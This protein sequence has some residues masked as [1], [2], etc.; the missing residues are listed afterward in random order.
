MAGIHYI[1]NIFLAITLVFWPIWFSKR[2]LRLPYINPLSIH[3]AVNVPVE[4]MKLVVGPMFLIED[5]LFD[6]GYQYAIA[7]SNLNTICEVIG[8]IFS[9]RLFGYLHVEKL[10]P[11]LMTRLSSAGLRNASTLFLSLFIAFFFLLSSNEFGF[12]NWI[13]NPR[14]GYQLHRSGQGLWFALAI[15][16][17]AVSFYIRCLS[18]KNASGVVRAAIAY[19]IISYF[20]GSKGVMLWYFESTLIMLWFVGYRKL[21]ILA[22]VGLP[23]IFMAMTFNLYLALG[24][25]FEPNSVVSYFDYYVNGASYYRSFHDGDIGLF[26][27]DIFITSFWDY[28]PR[29]VWPE[30]PVVYGVTIINEVFFPGHAELT[31]TP[32]FGGAVTQFADFG[33]SG[34]VVFG[35]FGQG[36]FLFA[37]TSYWFYFKPRVSL[38]AISPTTAVLLIAMYAPGFGA[39]FPVGLRA[40]LILFTFFVIY[41]VARDRTIKRKVWGGYG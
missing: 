15:Y 35:L 16:S 5:G 39:F 19:T 34:L 41:F 9:L 11:S 27:G 21:K 20:L 31:H 13:L 30:K 37:L 7:A 2:Y 8:V 23:L 28:I 25:S 29:I 26:C 12:F 14:E 32:A 1:A 17:L 10:L 36:A 4:L 40:S 38:S 24:E 33:W 3:V 6:I 22:C 18:F